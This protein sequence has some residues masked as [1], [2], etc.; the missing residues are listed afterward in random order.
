MF[1]SVSLHAEQAE[2]SY[3]ANLARRKATYEENCDKTTADIVQVLK[4]RKELAEKGER[5]MPLEA[6]LMVRI[7]V[8]AVMSI[9]ADAMLQAI[10]SGKELPSDKDIEY[11]S[12]RFSSQC[13]NN[14][15]SMLD[16][17]SL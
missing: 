8:L 1:F 16:S 6:A 12:K 9:E 14:V 3:Y 11:A 5:Q 10:K 13:K 4:S 15:F 7:G 17:F 2:M